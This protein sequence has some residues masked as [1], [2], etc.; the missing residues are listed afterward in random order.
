MTIKKNIQKYEF[1]TPLYH[2]DKSFGYLNLKTKN[3][4]LQIRL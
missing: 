1:L 3:T 4:L 2:L